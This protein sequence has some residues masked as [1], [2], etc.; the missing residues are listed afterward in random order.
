M[1]GPGTDTSAMATDKLYGQ[2]EIPK[3]GSIKSANG[4]TARGGGTGAHGIAIAHTDPS[5][6][7]DCLV[8]VSKGAIAVV[9][10][11]LVVLKN[12]RLTN[13]SLVEISAI[14]IKSKDT[15]R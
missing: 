5:K 13:R 6:P 7:S 9:V 4:G 15:Y 10:K 12:V 8:T 1:F 11:Q 2:I 14:L 3:T